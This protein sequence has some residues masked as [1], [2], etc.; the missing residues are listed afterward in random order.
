[1]AGFKSGVG[2]P[3]LSVT[4]RSGAC[5]DLACVAQI[6]RAD[7]IAADD[8][9]CHRVRG[10]HACQIRSHI[11][12]RQDG[13]RGLRPGTISDAKVECLQRSSPLLRSCGL[14]AIRTDAT[15]ICQGVHG[16]GIRCRAGRPKARGCVGLVATEAKH[17]ANRAHHATGIPR[18]AIVVSAFQLVGM[19][20][21]VV[22]QAAKPVSKSANA[23][24]RAFGRAWLR[25]S[26]ARQRQL[27]P[28][29]AQEAG[30]RNRRLVPGPPGTRRSR[31]IPPV[32]SAAAPTP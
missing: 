24:G 14:P 6:R 25:T 27:R 12:A 9:I 16:P 20:T 10:R 13:V 4:L 23:T 32:A 17:V 29:T 3:I 21:G 2:V 28:A 8:S 15:A 5:T 19:D 1:V 31:A 30:S 7:G 22:V 18:T 26:P 11:E